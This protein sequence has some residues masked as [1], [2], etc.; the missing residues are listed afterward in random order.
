LPLIAQALGVSVKA[1]VAEAPK[2]KKR[3]PAPK[4]QQQLER[5]QA[6]PKAKQRLVIE[7]LDSLLA[8]S[9]KRAGRMQ[10]PLTEL[11]SRNNKARQLA[12]FV[13]CGG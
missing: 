6:L 2:P 9:G 5:L 11:E 7:V 4:L 1:L 3:G 13:D 10:Q 8:Q 12:G